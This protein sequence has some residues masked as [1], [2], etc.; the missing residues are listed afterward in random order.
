MIGIDH[1]YESA[2]ELASH[3]CPV[4]TLASKYISIHPFIISN[5]LPVQELSKSIILLV[6]GTLAQD[7]PN[8]KTYN[9]IELVKICDVLS[10]NEGNYH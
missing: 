9:T 10:E 2:T 4:A 8:L 7:L 1:G 5:F 3:E 6:K